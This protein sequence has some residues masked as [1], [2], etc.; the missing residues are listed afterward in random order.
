[1][2]RV[3]TDA[4]PHHPGDIVYVDIRNRALFEHEGHNSFE[5]E[6]KDIRHR[7][8]RLRVG[9]AVRVPGA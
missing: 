2:L 3:R 5:V 7:Y 1:M 9:K 6:E 8:V 4:S